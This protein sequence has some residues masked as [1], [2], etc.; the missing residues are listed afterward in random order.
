[1]SHIQYSLP[2]LALLV[3]QILRH[4]SLHIIDGILL[5]LSS[6]SDYWDMSHATLEIIDSLCRLLTFSLFTH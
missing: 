1:M 6:Y 4:H 2:L 5:T 3:T